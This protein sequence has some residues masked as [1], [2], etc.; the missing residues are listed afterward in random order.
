MRLD[1]R[2]TTAVW[3]PIPSVAPVTTTDLPEQLPEYREGGDRKVG[4]VGGGHDTTS[5]V[6]CNLV[7]EI[8]VLVNRVSFYLFNQMDRLIKTPSRL[9][10]QW[11]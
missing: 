1:W 11:R 5:P 2:V 7:S 9:R 8:A 10:C 3:N 4:V 6:L